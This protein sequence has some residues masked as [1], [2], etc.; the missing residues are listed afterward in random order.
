MQEQGTK[1]SVDSFLKTHNRVVQLRSLSA[2]LCP[3]FLEVLL[4]N[5][6]EGVQL[7]VQEHTEVDYK[8]RFKGRPELE[9]LKAKISPQ[10]HLLHFHFPDSL[11]CSSLTC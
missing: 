6:P 11:N 8:A 2:T 4:K 5:P 10:T 7:C 1:M 3:I 9:G